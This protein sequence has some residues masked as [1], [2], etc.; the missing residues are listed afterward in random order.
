MSDMDRVQ[1]SAAEPPRNDL[2]SMTMT[3]RVPVPYSH[4]RVL[5]SVKKHVRLLGDLL[6]LGREDYVRYPMS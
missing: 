6:Q 4:A 1:S 3:I 5:E 2:A